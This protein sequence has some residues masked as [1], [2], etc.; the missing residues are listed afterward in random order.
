MKQT[1]IKTFES[2]FSGMYALPSSGN[3]RKKQ[4]DLVQTAW[5]FAYSVFWNNQVYSTKEINEAKQYISQWL[6]G[7]NSRKAFTNFCQ[8]V[9][10]GRLN[11]KALNSV[12]LSLPSLWF[13]PENPEGYSIIKEWLDEIRSIRQSLPNFKVE[14]KALAEAVQEFSE[15]PTPENFQ[16]WRNYFIEKDEPVLLNLFSV[17]CSNHT[18]LIQ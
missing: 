1:A 8:Q 3:R 18:F 14:I 16:Y 10:L 11:I 15:E 5:I 7:R 2:P 13:D 6:T 17:F 12:F 4:Y 9:I